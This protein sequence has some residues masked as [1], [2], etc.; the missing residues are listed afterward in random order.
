MMKFFKILIFFY[1]F[2][3]K[4][5]S[6]ECIKI[7]FEPTDKKTIIVVLGMHRSGTSLISNY[8]KNKG[9]NFGCNLLPAARDNPSG[10]FEDI[11]IAQF[12]ESV[13]YVLNLPYNS[14]RNFPFFHNETVIQ[15]GSELLK[16]KLINTNLFSFKDPRTARLINLWERIFN[17]LD[18][19]FKFVF[20]FRNPISVAKSLYARNS[21]PFI[22]SYYMYL[23]HYIQALHYT[24]D[25]EKYF[26]D[27]EKLLKN[28][29]IEHEKV[30]DNNLCHYQQNYFDLMQSD[31]PIDLK[32]LYFLISSNDKL[33]NKYLNCFIDEQKNNLNKFGF[34][35]NLINKKFFNKEDYYFNFITS[36]YLYISYKELQLI[37]IKSFLNIN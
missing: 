5:Y 37:K 12:N 21:I 9:I 3:A 26:E 2:S 7:N 22:K 13:L 31:I 30:V 11:D 16:E 23:Q 20:I 36:F 25:K 35:Y 18:C 27:Y 8:L 19:N 24:K 6:E 1:F 10:F 4:L 32:R 29:N 17:K 34:L 14:I 33:T 15:Y 28:N